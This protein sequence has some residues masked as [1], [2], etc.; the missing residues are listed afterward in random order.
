MMGKL[1]TRND[2]TNR[3]P[4]IYQ[5]KRRGQSINFY[6][7]FNYDRGNYQNSYR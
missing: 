5:S 4:L 2:G 7:I 6:D 1:T 3:Q